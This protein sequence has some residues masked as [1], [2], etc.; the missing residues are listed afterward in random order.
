[1][2][3]QKK[4]TT[5]SDFRSSTRNISQS[6]RER[7]AFKGG[8]QNVATNLSACESGFEKAIVIAYTIPTT[9]PGEENQ[10]AIITTDSF[11]TKQ[12]EKYPAGYNT[13]SGSGVTVKGEFPFVLASETHIN[14]KSRINTFLLTERNSNT[15]ATSSHDYDSFNCRKYRYE[16]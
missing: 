8:K 3:N 4:F 9:K 16:K 1:M 15:K 6:K 5:P 10:T 14:Q 2:K 7:A 13:I 12:Y 11:F